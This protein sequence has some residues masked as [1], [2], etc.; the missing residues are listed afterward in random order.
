MDRCVAR[1]GRAREREIDG[2]C[3]GGVVG[4]VQGTGGEWVV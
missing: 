2:S 1:F 3:D 4:R